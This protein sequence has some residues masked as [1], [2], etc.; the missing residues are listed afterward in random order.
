ME[1][2]FSEKEDQ[3]LTKTVL[4]YNSLSPGDEKERLEKKLLERLDLLIFLIPRKNG[5]VKEEDITE[6]YL[7]QREKMIRIIQC[8]VIS[9]QSFMIYLSEV[10]RK[11]ARVFA[12]QKS[13]ALKKEAIAEFSYPDSPEENLYHLSDV[14]TSYEAECNDGFKFQGLYED[15]DLKELTKHLLAERYEEDKSL[16]LVEREIK[17]SLEIRSRRRDF[18]ALLLYVPNDCLV[19]Q[20]RSIAHCLSVEEEAVLRFFA[21]KDSF[22]ESQVKAKKE[23][24][25][26][27]VARHYKAL[28]KLNYEYTRE[29]ISDEEKSA[30]LSQEERIS[31]CYIRRIKQLRSIKKG[32]SQAEISELMDYTRSSICQGVKKAVRNLEEIEKRLS[33]TI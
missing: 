4:Y 14:E 6:F 5:Y 8:Y 31:K 1:D 27:M 3:R 17:R 22:I 11:R 9:K 26:A 29:A 20:S 7:M 33:L 2:Y 21:L 24:I 18:I 32:L 13:R 28:M 23:M 12:M 16:T 10:L 25:R 30:L 15:Y 19:R